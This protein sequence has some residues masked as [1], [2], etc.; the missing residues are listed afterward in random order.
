MSRARADER[1]GAA[2]HHCRRCGARIES[3]ECIGSCRFFRTR[4]STVTDAGAPG[5]ARSSRSG[6]GEPGR[7]RVEQMV[8]FQHTVGHELHCVPLLLDG[9][10]SRRIEGGDVKR[11]RSPIRPVPGPRGRDR[12]PDR[13]WAAQC[14]TSRATR[15]AP[16]APR[17]HSRWYVAG[18]RAYP[19]GSGTQNS[20]SPSTSALEGR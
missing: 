18:T 8:T 14:I 3:E 13:T 11:C 5:R 16:S 2:E 4:P 19:A 12:R 6:A 20:S 15:Q 10:H 7:A 9:V 17:C 1:R